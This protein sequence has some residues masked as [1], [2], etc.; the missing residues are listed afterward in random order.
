MSDGKGWRSTSV[1]EARL[2]GRRRRYNSL[3]AILRYRSPSKPSFVVHR[4]DLPSE[5]DTSMYS[6]S[7]AAIEIPGQFSAPGKFYK[8]NQGDL[9]ITCRGSVSRLFTR[10]P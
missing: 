9:L 2:V 10:W 6:V 4:S 5:S 7:L 1:Q 8:Q 3:L